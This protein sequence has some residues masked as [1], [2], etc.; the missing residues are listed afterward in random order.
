M[1]SKSKYS[2]A[3]DLTP[4][5]S[6]TDFLSFF[7]FSSLQISQTKFCKFFLANLPVFQAKVS[8]FYQTKFSKFLESLQVLPDKILKVFRAKV[9][10]H[11]WIRFHVIFSASSSK[12]VAVQDLISRNF[13]NF[14]QVFK[15]SSLSEP[16][17]HRNYYVVFL[18]LKPSTTDS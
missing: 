3:L 11:F 7:T 18:P 13:F 16:R 6:Y 5:F 10:N 1:D 15:D 4:S 2:H 9:S 17:F 12:P 14:G 8:K